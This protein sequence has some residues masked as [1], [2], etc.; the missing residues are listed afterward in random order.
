[1]VTIRLKI[2]K[3]D[4]ENI[5]LEATSN[6]N[7]EQHGFGTFLT[8]LQPE[9]VECDQFSKQALLSAGDRSGLC[10]MEI[11]PNNILSWGDPSHTIIMPIKEINSNNHRQNQWVSKIQ[12]KEE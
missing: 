12:V 1:M 8:D 10:G 7:T 6:A 9:E 4:E 5:L 2:S 3:H 11:W